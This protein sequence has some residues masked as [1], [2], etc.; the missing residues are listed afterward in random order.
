M[1]WMIKIE[2]VS[3]MY[4]LGLI[5]SGTIQ[6]DIK[7][8]LYK[9]RGKEN[10]FLMVGE[11]NIRDSKGGNYIWALKDINLELKKGEVLGII[12]KNGAGKSTLLKLLSKVTKPTS[13]SIVTKGKIA[14]LLEVGTGFH[15]EL[16]GRENIYLNGAILGMKKHEI[17]RKFD[18]IV[19]FSGCE[20]YIDSPVK[21][22]SSGMYVRLAFAV[23]AHLE[24]DILVV[25]EVLA[26]GDAEFQRKAIGKM[27]DVSKG[28]GRTV[29]FVSHNMASIRSLC[30][31]GILM[32]NG[33]IIKSGEINY[34]V[35]SYLNK[36][37]KKGYINNLN[38]DQILSFQEGVFSKHNPQFT[39]DKVKILNKDGELENEFYSDQKIIIQIDVNALYEIPD[40]KLI[41][42]LVD[43]QGNIILASQISDDKE[44]ISNQKNKLNIGKYSYQ[45]TIP[46][47]TF[48]SKSIFLSIN[49]IYF[50]SQHIIL[51]K[52]LKI[53]VNFSG[54]NEVR[55]NLGWERAFIRQSY[56]WSQKTIK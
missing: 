30:T 47:N 46:E 7:R 49:A 10:P 22:Y 39:I 35:D 52:I 1:S 26:V 16:T 13:G 12:G 50:K 2:D 17:N 14:S 53:N 34:I 44:I 51:N 56:K 48:G 23:A 31:K 6:D 28:E 37:L 9:W 38:K 41:I 45:C 18:E 33:K 43:Q 11:E 20:R 40:F 4:R 55:G 29:L 21:R 25:D 27:K 24:P 32:E 8:L 42:E 19:D 3:K 54:I 36:N 15:P 5:G